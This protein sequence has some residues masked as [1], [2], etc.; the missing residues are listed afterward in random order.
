MNGEQAGRL[1]Y[2][3]LGGWKDVNV[4]NLVNVQFPLPQ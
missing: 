2:S 3:E 1:R 4:V